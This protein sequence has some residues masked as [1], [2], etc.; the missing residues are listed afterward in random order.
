MA[1]K[2]HLLSKNPGCTIRRQSYILSIWVKPIW[3]KESKDQNLNHQSIK[4][5]Q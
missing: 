2:H 3:T 1:K 4:R 5:C